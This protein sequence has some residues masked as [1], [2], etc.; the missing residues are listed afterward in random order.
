MKEIF[1]IE[2]I[3]TIRCDLDEQETTVNILRGSAEITIYTSDNTMLTKL[4]KLFSKNKD[5]WRCFE[6][7]KG[8]NISDENRKKCS[9]RFKK[10]LNK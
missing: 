10:Y 6:S 5:V 3:E 9:E 2:D 4:S 8:K 1:N 7:G